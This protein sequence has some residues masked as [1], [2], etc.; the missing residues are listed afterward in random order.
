M[1]VEATSNRPISPSFLR[2][3][4]K[5]LSESPETSIYLMAMF[6]LQPKSNTP[7]T[8]TNESC[9]PSFLRSRSITKFLGQWRKPNAIN[10]PLLRFVSAYTPVWHDLE[11]PQNGRVG[12]VMVYGVGFTTLHGFVWKYGTPKSPG[13][14]SC[15]SFN[16]DLYAIPDLH[17]FAVST[18]FLHLS[19]WFLI[20]KKKKKQTNRN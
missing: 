14:S 13:Y 19:F 17:Q 4:F 5:A 11:W 15:L 8:M 7:Q 12:L 9:F 2:S 16:L 10:R 3:G 18:S 6:W 1:V 20:V